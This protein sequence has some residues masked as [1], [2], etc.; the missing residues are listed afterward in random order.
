MLTSVVALAG[1]GKDDPPPGP[2]LSGT[3]VELLKDPEFA[4]G[5]GAGWMMGHSFTKPNRQGR[6]KEYKVVPEPYEIQLVPYGGIYTNNLY[7]ANA[8]DDIHWQWEEGN[9]LNFQDP[10]TGQFIENLYEHKLCINNKILQ[11]DENGLEFVQYNNWGLDSND[12]L[13]DTKLV[14][15]VKADKKGKISLYYDT[16]NEIRNAAYNYLGKYGEDVWPHMLLLQNFKDGD[17]DLGLYSKVIVKCTIK[18]GKIEKVNDWPRG[19]SDRLDQGAAVTITTETPEGPA[20]PDV[21]IGVGMTL[22]L[23]ANPSICVF[24]PA[25]GV[26]GQGAQ[27]GTVMGLEQWG[28]AFYRDNLEEFGYPRGVLAEGD[29]VTIEYDMIEEINR[30]LEIFKGMDGVSNL[31]RSAADY[32]FS[33]FAFGFEHMGNWRTDY[34]VSGVSVLAT[35]K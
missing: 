18:M 28:Q 16:Y 4:K 15:K 11:N 32:G 21:S 25:H 27:G 22:R 30:I 3:T 23:K 26:A 10:Y 34:E 12:P 9:H 2:S 17:Y 13:R 29:T 5:F 8:E 33:Q 24:F 31:G 19:Y 7:S 35:Y 6:V 20:L 1:C 14:K